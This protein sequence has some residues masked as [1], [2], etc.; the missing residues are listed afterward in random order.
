[1]LC[2]RYFI[3]CDGQKGPELPQPQ[4][5]EHPGQ[6]FRAMPNV[7][8]ICECANLSGS[9]DLEGELVDGGGQTLTMVHE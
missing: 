8:S 6:V 1:M 5:L 7:F 2:N 3:L 4:V 9:P